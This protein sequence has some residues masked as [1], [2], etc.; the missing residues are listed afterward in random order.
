MRQQRLLAGRFAVSLPQR[1]LRSQQP[2]IARRDQCSVGDAAQDCVPS[3]DARRIDL[4]HG[5][6]HGAA[7]RRNA[8]ECAFD[9][10]DHAVEQQADSLFGRLRHGVSGRG[11][12]RRQRQHD[13]VGIAAR[14]GGQ[15]QT[16][17]Q[18]AV[19]LFAVRHGNAERGKHFGHVLGA[20][21]GALGLGV[22]G[23]VK[24]LAGRSHLVEPAERVRKFACGVA[25]GQR[26]FDKFVT[27]HIEPGVG[28]RQAGAQTHQRGAGRFALFCQRGQAWRH[29]CCHLVADVAEHLG[30]GFFIGRCVVGQLQ[31]DAL[32]V[33]DHGISRQAQRYGGAGCGHLHRA[34]GLRKLLGR[35]RINAAGFFAG[36]VVVKPAAVL[37]PC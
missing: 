2:G 23:F 4:Q 30:H 36:A 22:V 14:L 10:V 33:V 6:L 5:L 37:L 21:G 28:C 24:R 20:A 25:T 3:H 19:G 16:R 7:F 1:S 9:S 17:H 31:A 32:A 12:L 26:D 11:K 13:G 8:L 18:I 29:G 27:K 34:V 15:V 35:C